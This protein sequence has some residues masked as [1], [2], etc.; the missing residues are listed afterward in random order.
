MLKN[1]QMFTLFSLYI[2]SKYLMVIALQKIYSNIRVVY[3]ELSF[4]PLLNSRL[5]LVF[6]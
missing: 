2:F 5:S 3:F 1:G 6:G 4:K